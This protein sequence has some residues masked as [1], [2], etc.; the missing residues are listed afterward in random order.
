MT[1]FW[2]GR[3]VRL[4]VNLHLCTLSK[5]EFGQVWR[6]LSLRIAGLS[7]R[8]RSLVFGL[9]RALGLSL[10]VLESE[11]WQW[12]VLYYALALSSFLFTLFLFSCFPL[13]W[14]LSSTEHERYVCSEWCFICPLTGWNVVANIQNMQ[15]GD[16]DLAI[17][18]FRMWA[19]I[20]MED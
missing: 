14:F 12:W 18:P 4:V 10:P 9:G 5:S 17:Y 15:S 1:E 19:Q 8:R 20:L 16:M 2:P 7:L 6:W 3:L 11:G 13:L